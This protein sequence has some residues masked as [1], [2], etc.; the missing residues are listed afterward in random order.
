MGLDLTTILLEIVNFLVLL[1]VLTRFLYRPVLAMIVRRQQQTEAA[2]ATLA[3]DRVALQAAQASLA[4]A[5]AGLLRQRESAMQRL[6]ADMRT[7]R[8]RRLALLNEEMGVEREQALARLAEQQAQ[9]RSVLDAVAATRAE[10]FLRDYLRRLAGPELEHALAELFLADL[11]AL[12]QAQ[13]YALIDPDA[14]GVAEISTVFEWT[15]AMRLRVENALCSALNRTLACHWRSDPDM[16]S[17]LS[18][19]VGGHVLEVSLARSLD[20]FRSIGEEAI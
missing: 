8:E 11:A 13:R 3:A 1:W 5:Q 19:R 16:L 9:Q 10:T 7:E 17:G 14:E 12:P 4:G 6:D 18:A 2:S 15:D 20:A